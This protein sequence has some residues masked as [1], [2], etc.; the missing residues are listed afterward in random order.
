M[1]QFFKNLINRPLKL[2]GE[3]KLV[4]D[5]V[6]NLIEHKATRYK[7]APIT[8]DILIKN[9]EKDYYLVLSG[10]R[11]LVANHSFMLNESYRLSFVEEIRKIIFKRMEEER[12]QSINEIF[13]NKMS[14]LT[15]IKKNLE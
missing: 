12:Q 15:A 1:I 3:E 11:I 9:P 14:L 4:Y 6:N 5:I 2:N 13:E 10:S 7:L 8:T